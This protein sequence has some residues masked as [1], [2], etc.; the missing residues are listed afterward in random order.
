VTNTETRVQFFLKL[1]QLVLWAESSGIRLMVYWYHRTEAQQFELYQKGRTLSGRIVTNCDGYKK[2][3]LHQRWRA[4]DLVIIG[5]DGT[6]I[7]EASARYAL[8]GE[9]WKSLGGKW[10]GDFKTPPVDLGH[11]EF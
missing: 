8:L 7:W 11:F 9:R 5:E 3:S 1:C 10:G 6:L 2:K 4:V